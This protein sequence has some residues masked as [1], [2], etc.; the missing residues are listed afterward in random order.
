MVV[1]HVTTT[2]PTPGKREPASSKLLQRT[3]EHQQHVK[4]CQLSHAAVRRT[5]TGPSQGGDPL[6]YNWWVSNLVV[7]SLA[8]EMYC[9]W[10]IN[11]SIFYI[12]I[13]KK[14]NIHIYPF[15]GWKKNVGICLFDAEN[16]PV[17][18]KNVRIQEALH[19]RSIQME[20]GDPRPLFKTAEIASFIAMICCMIYD[21]WFMMYDLL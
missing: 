21:V 6:N 19:G 14:T 16:L 13:I 2:P 5:L 1:K 4:W 8:E 10:M 18:P 17:F 9:T 3:R 20:F 15:L 7:L 11:W 12:W